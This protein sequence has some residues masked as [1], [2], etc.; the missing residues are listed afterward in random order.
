MIHISIKVVHLCKSIQIDGLGASCGSKLL[1]VLSTSQFLQ[2]HLVGLKV[3]CFFLGSL[4]F[5]IACDSRSL[6]VDMLCEITL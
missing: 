5:L 1:L 4:W 6:V 3:K 2:S